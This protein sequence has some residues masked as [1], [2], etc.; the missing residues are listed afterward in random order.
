MKMIFAGLLLSLLVVTSKAGYPEEIEHE[1]LADEMEDP[2][3]GKYDDE[4]PSEYL[5]LLFLV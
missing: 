4:P 5:S 2:A 3:E 1:D